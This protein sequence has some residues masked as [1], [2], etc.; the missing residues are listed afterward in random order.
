MELEEGIVWFHCAQCLTVELTI[1]SRRIARWNVLE[2][3][4]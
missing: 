3:L 1:A 2:L 4:L